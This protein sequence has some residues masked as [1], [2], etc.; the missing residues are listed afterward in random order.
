M[1]RGNLSSLN[2]VCSNVSLVKVKKRRKET[3]GNKN[4]TPG[5]SKEWKADEHIRDHVRCLK[6]N[7]E[8]TKPYSKVS[9]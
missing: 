6:Q 3:V 2:L 1:K 9:A 4:V 8:N 7:A 5:T